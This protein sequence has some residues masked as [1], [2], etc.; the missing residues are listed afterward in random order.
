MGETTERQ[1][2][3]QYRDDRDSVFAIREAMR[4]PI[5]WPLSYEEVVMMSTKRLAY[6]LFFRDTVMMKNQIFSWHKISHQ[7]YAEHVLLF[8]NEWE[9]VV[10]CIV[11]ENPDNKWIPTCED[12]QSIIKMAREND[13][14]I[15]DVLLHSFDSAYIL[16]MYEIDVPDGQ[17]IHYHDLRPF[18]VPSAE[19]KHL[20]ARFIEKVS[21][22]ARIKEP[23]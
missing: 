14:P 9:H 6:R 22:I 4:N 2:N 23:I 20:L 8:K 10:H 1:T 7:H 21:D 3:V 19:E 17:H 5:A 12:G 16:A 13:I 11:F 18:G 15:A